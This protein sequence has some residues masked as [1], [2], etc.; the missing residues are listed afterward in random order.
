M[1]IV[2]LRA[3]VESLAQR[4]PVVRPPAAASALTDAQIA[5]AKE[6]GID[7]ARYAQMRARA[8]RTAQ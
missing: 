8:G 4:A 3:R 2:A 1:S 7:P 6:Y 5:I